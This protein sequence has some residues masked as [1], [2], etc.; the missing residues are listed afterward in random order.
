M[1]KILIL[2]A[3]L[4]ISIS[5]QAQQIDLKLN[6]EVG[7]VYKQNFISTNNMAQEMSGMN[8][9]I[10]IKFINQVSFKVLGIENDEYRLEIKYDST[11]MDLKSP[12]FSITAASGKPEAKDYLSL[13]LQK[14]SEKAFIIRMTKY[15]QI[16]Q[17]ENFDEQMKSIFDDLSNVDPG[18]GPMSQMK[19]QL[20]QSY[21]KEAFKNNIVTQMSFFPAK[22]VGIGEKWI[23]NTVMKNGV[24]VNNV[25]EYELTGF[26]SNTATLKGISTYALTDGNGIKE[27][28]GQKMN[29]EIS[30]KGIYEIKIDRKSGWIIESRLKNEMTVNTTAKQG[31]TGEEMK[32]V[33]KSTGEIIMTNK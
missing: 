13:Y 9:T 26:D 15:G 29:I 3:A 27:V 7:K 4:A 5:L 28:N 11:S 18:T 12:F 22:K 23:D 33:T 19:S 14:Y 6:L 8:F 21:G 17:M 10:D 2:I 31:E 24:P 30:G 1:K 25:T 20:E 32:F 16:T